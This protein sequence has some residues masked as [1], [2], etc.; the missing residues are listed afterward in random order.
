MEHSTSNYKGAEDQVHEA[1]VSA[2]RWWEAFGEHP[3]IVADYK[4]ALAQYRAQAALTLAVMFPL[5]QYPD[6]WL[7]GQILPGVWK[8]FYEGLPG[9]DVALQGAVIGALKEIVGPAAGWLQARYPQLAEH[10][11]QLNDEDLRQAIRCAL[12]LGEWNP[13]TVILGSRFRE[14]R[15]VHATAQ[16]WRLSRTLDPNTQAG[17]YPPIH[18]RDR[19]SGFPHGEHTRIHPDK[20]LAADDTIYRDLLSGAPSEELA[21]VVTLRPGCI[22]EDA[23]AAVRG[24][25]ARVR[26]H[27]PSEPRKDPGSRPADS[28]R[29]I[30]VHAS[31]LTWR[32]GA[33]PAASDAVF[34]RALIAAEPLFW[35]SGK[36]PSR[37]TTVKTLLGQCGWLEPDPLVV[38]PPPAAPAG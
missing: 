35:P 5:V 14:D 9:G 4:A 11:P 30:R 26:P 36:G 2:Q 3:A 32:A 20:L 13:A 27:V 37:D 21:L 31:Y 25:W 22:A 23:E 24:I 28:L 8:V 18:E 15:V 6:L 17:V 38:L 29:Q 16:L 19:V 1:P 33:G 7:D 12:L 10:S 34:I